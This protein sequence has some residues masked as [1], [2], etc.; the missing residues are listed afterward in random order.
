MDWTPFQSVL[1]MPD[2]SDILSSLTE[3]QRAAVTHVDG[4]LLVLAGPGS[5]KT[6][7]VTRRI[8]YLL[9]QGIPPQQIVGLTFTNKAA[10]EMQ[11]RIQQLRPGQRVWLSTFHRWC[12]FLLRHYA[13]YVG[14]DSGFTIYDSQDSQTALKRVLTMLGHERSSVSPSA[15]ARQISRYK[16]ELVTAERLL[17]GGESLQL[18]TPA[19]LRRVVAEVYPEYQAFLRRANAVDFDDLLLLVANLLCENEEIRADLDD[20]YRYVLVDE[21]QDTNH[22]QYLLLR[23]VSLQ[24]PHIAVTGDPDQSV[25]GW[26]GANIDNI[27]NF[28]RDFGHAQVVRL[29]Q[30]YRSTPAI[31]RVA[32]QLI[33]RNT[34]R[35]HKELFTENPDGPPVRLTRYADQ[36][37]EARAIAEQIHQA[38]R[39][40]R[41]P[42]EFAIFYRVNALSRSFEVALR[43]QG[44]PYQVVSGVEYFQRREVKDCVA[45][46]QLLHNPRDDVSLLRIIN[47]PARKIG[48]ATVERLA[49]YAHQHRLPLLEAARQAGLIDSIASRSAVQVAKFVA[50]YDRL[51]ERVQEPVEAI[52]RAVL[53]VTKM[54]DLYRDGDDPLDQDRLANIEELLSAARQF[55]CEHAGGDYLTAFL[56]Q[57]LLVNES[58]DW[59]SDAQR[60]TLMTLHAAKGLEFPVVY[61]VALE[62]KLIPHERSRHDP[63]SMEEERRLLFVGITRAMRE[64]RLSYVRRREYRGA[65]QMAAPSCFLLDL[66]RHEM[67]IDNAPGME[68]SAS[69]AAALGPVADSRARLR[70]RA[71]QPRFS[72]LTTAAELVASDQADQGTSTGGPATG[73][74]N[75]SEG[76]PVTGGAAAASCPTTR[77]MGPAEADCG[78]EQFRAGM[79]VLHPEHGLGKI[80]KLSG[81]GADR[82]A[83]VNFVTGAGSQQI[84]LRD[85]GLKPIA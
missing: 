5:G 38:I 66:P 71:S 7:V 32:D 31:L 26:R 65:Q 36:T 58:D 67:I 62:D 44:V 12:A 39:E 24:Y 63:A 18:R 79:A 17:D 82:Q 28:E 47:V 13:H 14:L 42:A 80:V 75:T 56:E 16:S 69:S 1:S 21:Y 77:V 57:V 81:K 85:G 60:V 40:G 3:S 30:N 34:Q 50:M 59:D 2:S 22:A 9:D 20:R 27:L 43:E 51:R 10:D 4:P 35:K 76:P 84:R 45:Y 11:R 33:V 73:C 70:Q 15:I 55:D 52:L 78:P 41:S 61:L 19:Q 8:A 74:S 64:L 48:K 68:L 54:R 23:A 6:R 37:A 29:E 83:T 72:G 46:L 49:A 53:D 25:Y